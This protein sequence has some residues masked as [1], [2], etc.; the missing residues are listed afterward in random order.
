[1]NEIIE[2]FVSG[3]QFSFYFVWTIIGAYV[4]VLLDSSSNKNDDT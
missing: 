2:Y 4:F 3:V 1:M